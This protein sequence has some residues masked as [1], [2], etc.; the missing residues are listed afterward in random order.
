MDFCF[1]LSRHWVI[2][3]PWCNRWDPSTARCL[4]WRIGSTTVNRWRSAL[5]C[6][7]IVE[8]NTDQMH[9]RREDKVIISIY[10]QYQLYLSWRYTT[11]LP[12][13]PLSLYRTRSVRRIKSVSMA[14][15]WPR[16]LSHVHDLYARIGASWV[17]HRLRWRGSQ[18]R[19]GE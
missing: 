12:L 11:F 1:P 13:T 4:V 2:F 8:K 14:R 10:R 15:L 18:G 16:L 9:V 5:G 19:M 7:I 17:R 3:Y 6:G